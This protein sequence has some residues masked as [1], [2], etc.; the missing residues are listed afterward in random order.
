MAGIGKEQPI[1]EQSARI[2]DLNEAHNSWATAYESIRPTGEVDSRAKAV[3]VASLVLIALCLA[4]EKPDSVNVLGFTFRARDW[5]V[6]GIPLTLVVLYSTVQLFLAWSI[7]RAKIE[8]AI[9]T[10]I[11]S[12]RTWLEKIVTRKIEDSREFNEEVAE[13][14]RRR[15]EIR[16]WYIAQ[17]ELLLQQTANDYTQPEAWLMDA[18]EQA[19]Q[20]RDALRAEYQRRLRD[21]G[22][23]EFHKKVDAVLAGRED[24]DLVIAEDALKDLKRVTGMRKARSLLDLVIPL[25][26]VLVA[27]YIFTITVFCPSYLSALGSYLSKGY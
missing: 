27:L 14:T 25:S 12:V 26:V 22:I 3:L 15:H 23:E 20:Q 10:P 16:D 7:Q 17:H 1:D 13:M 19:K 8:H 5:L 21:A 11:M 24:G 4:T 9:F 18:F 2:A 6:L